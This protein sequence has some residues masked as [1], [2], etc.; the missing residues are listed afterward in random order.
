MEFR[1]VKVSANQGR[2]KPMSDTRARTRDGGT[3]P[4]LLAFPDVFP[5][6]GRDAPIGFFSL[7]SAPVVGSSCTITR[8][9]KNVD[10]HFVF[11]RVS[12]T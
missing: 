5:N 10:F 12:F 9:Q 11:P 7:K 6:R 3:T 4:L 1:K 8:L 2:T